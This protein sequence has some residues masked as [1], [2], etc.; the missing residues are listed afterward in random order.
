M[1]DLL[2][3]I[4]GSTFVISLLGLAGIFTFRL[5]E[6]NLKRVAFILVSFSGGTLIGG[7]FLHL[8]P[9]SLEMLAPEYAFMLVVVGFSLF[10]IMETFFHWHLCQECDV[11]PYTYVMLVGDAIHNFIDGIIIAATYFVS[12]PLGITTTVL[13]FSH[14]FPQQLGLFGVLVHGGLD[15]KKSLLYSYLTQLTVIVGG[16]IGFLLA[17]TG[18]I[19]YSMMPFAAGGFIYIAASDLVPEIHKSGGR[20]KIIGVLVFFAGISFMVALKSLGIE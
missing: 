18:N 16:I 15:K 10:M 7:A 3:Y 6:R 9:E 13:I 20:K 12:I 1:A 8:L 19:A 4:L 14:E 2:L 17:G 11:H 5:R